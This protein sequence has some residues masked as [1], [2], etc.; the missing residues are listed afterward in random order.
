MIKGYPDDHFQMR[1]LARQWFW[2]QPESIFWLWFQVLCWEWGRPP[3][4]RP[5]LRTRDD[6]TS[7]NVPGRHLFWTS[8]W[9]D[10]LWS[11]RPSFCI[12][13]IFWRVIHKHWGSRH[14]AWWHIH[15]PVWKIWHQRFI[16]EKYIGILC[17]GIFALGILG[18]LIPNF[19]V[20]VTGVLYVLH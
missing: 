4:R 2:S 15:F 8:P 5:L 19:Q 11:S 3:S 13:H 20:M 17:L 6:D 10:N 14:S 12:H 7:W 1:K 9:L 18:V 16:F